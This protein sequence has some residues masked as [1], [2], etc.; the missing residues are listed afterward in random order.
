MIEP[1]SVP[2][3]STHMELYQGLHLGRCGMAPRPC[4][5]LTM[6]TEDS[7]FGTAPVK[8]DQSA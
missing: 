7:V 3:P 8:L 5:C 6:W 4:M 2:G 1:L